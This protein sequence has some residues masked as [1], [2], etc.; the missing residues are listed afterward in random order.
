MPSTSG[1][2]HFSGT[3]SP[4]RRLVPTSADGQT[5]T[6]DVEIDEPKVVEHLCEA[7]DWRWIGHDTRFRCKVRVAAPLRSGH[8]HT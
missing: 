7:L 1:F 4:G 6:P 8:L 2:S 5:Q 3:G